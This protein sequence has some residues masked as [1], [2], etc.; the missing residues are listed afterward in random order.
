[1]AWRTQKMCADCPFSKDGAGAHLRRSLRPGRMAE[2][3]RGLLRGE[4]FNCH[5]TTHETGNGTNLM[6]SGAIEFQEK[7]GVSSQLQRIAERLGLK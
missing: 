6:C 4:H 2:I 3:K 5:K 1:M 7:H